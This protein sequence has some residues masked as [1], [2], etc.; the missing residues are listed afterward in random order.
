LRRAAR[1]F[2]DE[3]F[4]HSLLDLWNAAVCNLRRRVEAYGVEL[5]LSTVKDEKGR[6]K[7]NPTGDGL[8]D[9]WEG[10]DELVLITGATRLGLLNKKAGKTLE[11]IN[12]TRNHVSPAHPTEETVSAQDVHGLFLLL[13]SNLF[14]LPMPDIGHSIAALFEPVK[15]VAGSWAFC[16]DAPRSDSKF[17]PR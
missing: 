5:F 3:Y 12:W 1:L 14:R 10:V 11:T 17:A 6:A 8:N 13:Q 7:Y 2:Q 4:E 9:R 16:R 15:S